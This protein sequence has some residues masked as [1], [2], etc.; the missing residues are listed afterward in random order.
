MSVMAVARTGLSS[1]SIE[2]FVADAPSFSAVENGLFSLA[3]DSCADTTAQK[4]VAPQWHHGLFA[5]KD[6]FVIEQSWLSLAQARSR[7]Q[8]RCLLQIREVSLPVLRSLLMKR[9]E[10][11]SSRSCE[12]LGISETPLHKTVSC[13]LSLRLRSRSRDGT[14]WVFEGRLARHEPSLLMSQQSRQSERQAVSNNFTA[15][16]NATTGDLDALLRFS[17]TALTRY[18][19]LPHEEAFHFT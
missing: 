16:T 10:S 9:I 4:Y 13:L 15:T 18:G 3:F 8:L 19:G 6:C 1:T 14:Q 17:V 12:Q 11:F 5:G 2:L 7:A